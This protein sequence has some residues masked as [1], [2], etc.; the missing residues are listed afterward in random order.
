MKRK[1]HVV[2]PGDLLVLTNDQE[3]F[4]FPI[5]LVLSKQHDFSCGADRQYYVIFDGWKVRADSYL[6]IR[7]NG[8]LIENFAKVS[9]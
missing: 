2:S 5:I 1:I 7:E 6:V 9:C 3:H 8:F 4:G